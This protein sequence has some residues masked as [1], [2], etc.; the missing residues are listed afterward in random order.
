L[1]KYSFFRCAFDIVILRH[2]Y[3]QDITFDVFAGRTQFEFVR[4]LTVFIAIF[5]FYPIP[6]GDYR[7]LSKKNKSDSKLF[8]PVVCWLFGK[9]AHQIIRPD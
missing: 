3:K 8:V 9:G 2:V 1:C 5:M 6:S 4:T 7:V